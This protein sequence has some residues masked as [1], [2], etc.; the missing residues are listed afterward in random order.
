MMSN[1]TILT[2]SYG[3]FS[4]TLEGFDDSFGTMKVIAEYFRD[5]AAHDRYFGAEPPQ[6]DAEVLARIAEREISRPVEARE[7]DGRIVLSTDTVHA[8]LN[9]ASP[10][11]VA[12]AAPPPLITSTVT[13]APLVNEQPIVKNQLIIAELSNAESVTKDLSSEPDSIAEKLQ[14]IRAVVSKSQDE[15]TEDD[16]F[17]DEYSENLAPSLDTPM[18]LTKRLTDEDATQI[19]ETQKI[20][21]EAPLED[22]TN[23]S[24]IRAHFDTKA[25]VETDKDAAQTAQ[26]NIQGATNDGTDTQHNTQAPLTVD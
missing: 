9:D 22:D 20:N 10:T 26:S 19:G 17:E 25:K 1:S 13:E 18:L 8:S 21:K 15:A 24:A 16:L 23:D 11:A 14:R 3:T 12:S 7:T 2:V 5:L 6:P 4:C